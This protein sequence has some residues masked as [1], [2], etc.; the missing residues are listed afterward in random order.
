ML[1]ISKPRWR[2]QT[3]KLRNL[4][5]AEKTTQCFS[6]SLRAN[7]KQISS[8]INIKSA[9]NA[10]KRTE[11]LPSRHHFIIGSFLALHHLLFL[12][13]R[14]A[15]ASQLIL[16]DNKPLALICSFSPTWLTFHSCPPTAPQSSPPGPWKGDCS[17]LSRNLVLFFLIWQHKIVNPGS[18]IGLKSRELRKAGGAKFLFKR[19]MALA[20]N[21]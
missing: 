14:E 16:S 6:W 8:K 21:C 9:L 2:S 13:V 1:I 19:L 10:D 7:L 15:A 3:L 20:A 12:T 18:L 5:E 11:I 4:C 17:Q